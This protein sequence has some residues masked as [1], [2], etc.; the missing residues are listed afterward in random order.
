MST[1]SYTFLDNEIQELLTDT[2]YFN[3]GFY[4][5]G[6]ELKIYTKGGQTAVD[7]W[8]K[9][10][11]RNNMIVSI[12]KIS[13]PFAEDEINLGTGDISEYRIVNYLKDNEVFLKQA[14]KV[15]SKINPP[16]DFPGLEAG[17]YVETWL[18]D[19]GK[20]FDFSKTFVTENLNLHVGDIV[21]STNEIN[22][23]FSSDGTLEN[24]VSAG[25]FFSGDIN[26]GNVTGENTDE[27]K[28]VSSRNGTLVVNVRI[29]CMFEFIDFSNSIFCYGD[30]GNISNQL[31]CLEE[32]SLSPTKTGYVYGLQLRIPSLNSDCTVVV[33]A[34]PK[35]FNFRISYRPGPGTEFKEII[36]ND[37]YTYGEKINLK[38][39]LNSAQIDSLTSNN[40]AGAKFNGLSTKS[41]D[42]QGTKY[43][44]RNLNCLSELYLYMLDYNGMSYD[45]ASNYDPSTETFTLYAV[46][47]INI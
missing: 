2:L 7:Y 19:D 33:K 32:G 44:D 5:K 1:Y 10:F 26:D 14:Y 18:T 25:K 6:S 17:T 46:Y 12:E 40:S 35:V 45:Y 37:A 13:H 42:S 39:L 16:K 15:G 30:N 31:E 22:F 4:E 8:T 11:S 28:V 27:L 38:T 47:N 29:S 3:F 34:Q 20:V 36:I 24:Q 43:F 23:I 21:D 9:Y 41:L